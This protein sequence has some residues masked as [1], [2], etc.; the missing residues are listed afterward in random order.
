M[1]KLRGRGFVEFAP[2]FRQNADMDE[3]LVF[4]RFRGP[5]FSANSRFSMRWAK[6]FSAPP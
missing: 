1:A 5:S 4:G 2:L 3:S 6:K